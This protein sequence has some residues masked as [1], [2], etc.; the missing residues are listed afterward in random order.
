MKIH[1]CIIINPKIQNCIIIN[2]KIHFCF[3]H[4][5]IQIID[6]TTLYNHS[7]ENTLLYNR[8][9]IQ[10]SILKPHFHRKIQILY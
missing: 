6:N 9:K 3:Y 7:P 10:I 8:P 2:P 1:S 4:P 5:K